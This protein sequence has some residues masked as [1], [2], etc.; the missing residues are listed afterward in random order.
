MGLRHRGKNRSV[1]L[2]LRLNQASSHLGR[3][4]RKVHQHKIYDFIV[5]KKFKKDHE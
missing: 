1:Q 4:V 5:S 3:A 2:G